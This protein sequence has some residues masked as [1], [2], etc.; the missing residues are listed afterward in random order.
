MRGHRKE[1]SRDSIAS[2]RQAEAV[3]IEALW[4]EGKQVVFDGKPVAIQATQVGGEGKQVVEGKQIVAGVKVPVSEIATTT[5]KE[6]HFDS[7]DVENPEKIAEI[8]EDAVKADNVFQG[9]PEC[10]MDG[11]SS[12]SLIDHDFMQ[13]AFGITMDPKTSFVDLPQSNS[14][15]DTGLK[16][17]PEPD[18]DVFEMYVPLQLA[19]D[20]RPELQ[21]SIPNRKT[22][23]TTSPSNKVASRSGRPQQETPF[24]VSPP[25]TCT[26]ARHNKPFNGLATARLSIVSPL[27]VVEMPKPRRPFSA[28]SLEELTADL[29]VSNAPGSKSATSNS[30]DDTRSKSSSGRSPRCCR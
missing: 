25:S 27:S 2:I 30:S 26:T 7:L 8:M 9:L 28:L 18:N 16:T 15:T 3:P 12:E 20:R 19:K 23:S 24:T 11:V 14:H 5:S 4:T 17:L 13:R 10:R 1:K 21:V 29:P 6:L 22:H